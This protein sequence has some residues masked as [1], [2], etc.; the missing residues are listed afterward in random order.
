MDNKTQQTQ[1][2]TEF[3]P[4]TETLRDLELQIAQE[5]RENDIFQKSV[6]RR[7][8]GKPFVF[9]DGP[10]TANGL[11]HVGHFLTRIYKDLFG[12]YKTMQGFYAPRRAGW[13]THGLPVELEIE[14]EL[15][16][17]NKK[18][19]EA[20]GIARFNEKCRESVWKYKT[21]WEEMTERIGFWIDLKNPYITYHTD[22]VESLWWTINQIWSKGLLYQG[23]KILP[24]CTRCGTSLSSHEV[25][26]GYKDVIDTSA[27]VKFRLFR[28]QN[29]K[30][31]VNTDLPIYV[32]AWTTTPWTLPG[33]VALA[34]G[35]NIEYSIVNLELS[36]DVVVCATERL[37]IL[38]SDYKILGKVKGKDL[39][40]LK[41][42]QIFE[43]AD[44]KSE[45]S[46]RIY[47]A[48]FVSTTDGTGVVHIAPMYGED[49]YA[50]GRA[51]NLPMKHTVNEQGNFTDSVVDFARKPA[52]ESNLAI[53]D[54]LKD[55]NNLF[56]IENY[57]HSYPHCWRCKTPLLYYA[58]SS[59]FIEVSKLRKQLVE[60]NKTVNWNPSHIKDGRF[61]EFI[62]EAKDWALSRERYWGTP[63]P[64]WR[65]EKCGDI[66]CVDSLEK[67]ETR[68]PKK[69]NQYFLIRH[70]YSERN[71]ND[72]IASRIEHDNYKITDNGAKKM[73]ATAIDLRLKGGI[74]MIFCSPFLR[75]RQTAEILADE[76][77]LE[78]KTDD[79]LKELDHGSGLEGHPH[80][81]CTICHKNIGLD[82][83]LFDGETRREVKARMM[84]FVRECEKKYEG[85]KIAIVSH[86]DP[87]WL[88]ESAMRCY[89]DSE[90]YEFKDKIYPTEGSVAKLNLK[91]YPYDEKGGIDPHRPYIDNVKISCTKCDG[92]MNRVSE[93]IDVWFDSG[94][95]PLA[96]WHYPF[97]NKDKIDGRGNDVQYPA[98]FIVEAIDQTRGWFY[99]LL[100]ISALLDRPAPY[101]NVSVLG[102]VTND[103]GKK[104]SKSE[105]AGEGFS[106]ILSKTSVDALRWY[107]Y[108]VSDVGDDKRFSL[109]DV[110][111]RA[112][113]FHMIL[114]NM[115]RFF[116]LYRAKSVKTIPKSVKPKNILDKWVY[117]RLQMTLSE[118]TEAMDGY[119][120]VKAA[121][122]IENF[123]VSDVSQW[124]L[125]MSRP[126]FQ[127]PETGSELLYSTKFFMSLWIEVVKMLA[128]FN[129]FFA[130]YLSDELQ[131]KGS[132]KNI[133]SIH[134]ADWT[135]TKA[136]KISDEKI[137]KEMNDARNVIS[138]G[139][140]QRKKNQIKV[141]QPLQSVSIKSKNKFSK[142]IEVMILLELNVKG[143]EYKT[144]L[145]EIAVLDETMTQE[146]INEGY[147][148]EI[149]RVIQD[150]RKEIGCGFQDKITLNWHTG[151]DKIGELIEANKKEISKATLLK[152]MNFSKAQA[153]MKATKELSIS[154]GVS[155]SLS[156]K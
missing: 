113:N 131:I 155:V 18:D 101:K 12:R 23:H 65:C 94:A 119:N 125:R 15:G 45:N 102:F 44:L 95:M 106:E 109:P 96:Q 136:L 76:M 71:K 140:A 7:R 156:I 66:D 17:K 137:L 141:R 144:K 99:T 142:D 114:L 41:Y 82:V 19:I 25:A 31:I 28:D 145:D 90:T 56:R 92:V 68:R 110:E 91:N 118:V 57:E 58:K 34:V 75:T 21:A 134:F 153:G 127:H 150:L 38:K 139:L 151:D 116:N 132:L 148:R 30:D 1:Q 13:D 59:W 37:D 81:E 126:K 105:G 32:L 149:I 6:K 117:A 103:K 5:W 67:L 133:Q 35:A 60:R 123:V 107:L 115:A 20:Y 152:E 40:G 143:I 69:G 154:D 61:G 104:L 79:R 70:A 98:D 130:E 112:K 62:K 89:D 128:P 54:Y 9:F 50:L 138:A 87:I 49:D 3:K 108:T 84:D 27:Y 78:F 53:I 43:V 124:W 51:N 72:I 64:L 48:D 120:A 4:I 29:I 11:P 39:V 14:K 8:R 42:D 122:A 100:T 52:R 88:L 80:K 26:Q 47:G 135:K 93:L 83:R 33:N 46:Q 36:G 2:K 85:K 97:D 146:L 24:Y 111:N 16:L 63:L 10:P 86:G 74:D 22:Y 147:V 77:K 121:R 73:R 55:N 129:P